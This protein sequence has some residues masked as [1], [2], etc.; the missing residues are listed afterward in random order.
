MERLRER[1]TVAESALVRLEE[2]MAIV[3]PSAMERDAAIQRFEFTFEA[4]WK[5]AKSFLFEVEGVDLGSPKS[6][7]RSCRET[8]LLTENQAVMALKMADDRNLTVHTYN[9]A[10]AV[11]IYSRLHAY[12]VLLRCWHEH[13]QEKM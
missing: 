5:A 8:G 10:L 13:M 6:V 2:V 7:I 12:S 11:E 1:M 4:I 3:Q 9:E